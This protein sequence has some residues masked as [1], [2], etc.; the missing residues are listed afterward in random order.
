MMSR[1]I[2]K[3][4]TFLILFKIH[5]LFKNNRIP[6]RW[7][8]WY[9]RKSFQYKK[10]IFKKDFNKIFCI[11]LSKTGTVSL[12]HA[13]N[14]LGIKAKHYPAIDSAM[15]VDIE[16]HDAI[17]DTPVAG[18]Y[19]ILDKKYPYSKFILTIRDIESWLISA[20]NHFEGTTR[21]GLRLKLRMHLYGVNGFDRDKFEM[22]YYKHYNDVINYFKNRSGDLLIM[23]IIDGEGWEKLCPFLNMKI[24]KIDFPHLNITIDKN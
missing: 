20:R 9:L 19:K 2:E 14:I 17:S 1:I 10:R 16:K 4:K 3:A 21:D 23:N 22:A 7:K 24:P 12:N 13:L 18:V 5:I 11:G 15:Y 8:I 6:L